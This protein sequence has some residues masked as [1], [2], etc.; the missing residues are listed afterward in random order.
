MEADGPV[1]RVGVGVLVLDKSQSSVI[2]GRRRSSL[3]D[4]KFAL[5]GGHLEFG[6]TW[7]ECAAREVL[8]ETGLVIH[9]VRFAGV[10]NTIMLKERRPWHYVTIFM[11]GELLDPTQEPQNL[12][13][14]KCHGWEWVEW[15]SI[16]EPVFE[17]LQTLLKSNYKLK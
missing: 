14:D 11:Q 16:P 10:T 1:P 2:V 7:E 13:P 4:S 12:E 17:P 6:E 9:N 3:G 5:P 8:E 15:P